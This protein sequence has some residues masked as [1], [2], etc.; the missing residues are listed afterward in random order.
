MLVR[1]EDNGAVSEIALAAS[2]A[3]TFDQIRPVDPAFSPVVT[4]FDLE[5]PPTAAPGDTI[6]FGNPRDVQICATQGAA[7]NEVSGALDW[8]GGMISASR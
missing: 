1:A 7:C 3:A 4:R 2:G 8:P 5:I 6:A